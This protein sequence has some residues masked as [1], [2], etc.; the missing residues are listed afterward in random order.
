[1]TC[2]QC[3]FYEKYDKDGYIMKCNNDRMQLKH[4]DETDICLYFK[5]KSETKKKP[6]RFKHQWQRDIVQKISLYD[7]DKL[8]EKTIELSIPY[9]GNGEKEQFEHRI[10]VNELN[11]RLIK[12][13]FL[14]EVI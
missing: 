5:H 8:L 2:K 9:T 10:V 14:T 4:Y 3:K 11:E 6:R 1:M 7:N 12:I 13:G